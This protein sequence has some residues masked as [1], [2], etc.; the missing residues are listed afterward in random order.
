MADQKVSLPDPSCV[1]SPDMK[2]QIVAAL[3]N[4]PRG[5]QEHAGILYKTPEGQYCW[6][7][8]VSTA[9]DRFDISARM[10]HGS[11]VAAIYHTHSE[12]TTKGVEKKDAMFSPEDINMANRMKVANYIK[13]LRTGQILGYTPGKTPT[14]G[15]PANRISYGDEVQP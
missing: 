6:T 9:N 3:M 15:P 2:Q 5:A 12:D 1:L 10:P 11:T 4:V 14:I 7:L 13:I 8:P